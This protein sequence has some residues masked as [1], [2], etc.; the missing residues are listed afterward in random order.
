MSVNQKPDF[1]MQLKFPSTYGIT[2]ITIQS[3]IQDYKNINI[4]ICVVFYEYICLCFPQ[5]QYF[6]IITLYQTGCS[7]III[8]SMYTTY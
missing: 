4:H 8:T 2:Y 6:L 5:L 7:F 3:I 1:S